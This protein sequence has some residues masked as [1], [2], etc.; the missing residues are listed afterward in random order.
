MRSKIARTLPVLLGV[1]LLL[2]VAHWVGADALRESLSTALG[3]LPLLFAL[4]GVRVPLEALATRRLLGPLAP[5]VP[6][7]TLARVQ[8]VF[9]AVST[10]APGGR[11]LAEASKAALLAS[12]VGAPASSAVATA[13][14]AASLVADALVAALGAGAVYALCGFTR[15]TGLT[16]LFVIA[17]ASLAALV[18]AATRSSFSPRVLL[19]FPRLARFLEGWRRAA[20]AQRLFDSRVVGLL[21]VARLAQVMMLG[22]ALAAGG[23]GFAPL[24]ALA[25]TALV[26]A[27]AVVGEAIPAQLGATDAVLVAAAPSL[28]VGLTHAATV[29]VLFHV[30]QL[31]WAAVGAMAGAL[32]PGRPATAR[33]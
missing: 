1:G 15:L 28:G 25:L 26:M 8:L 11:V 22:A 4:E 33:V 6:L 3:W 13:S 21:F 30:V 31:A 29:A 20:R 5:R 16:L 7:L 14:Q 23:A 17:C 27:S 2:G 12:F 19:R 10:C 18:A 9:Y 32:A 24:R